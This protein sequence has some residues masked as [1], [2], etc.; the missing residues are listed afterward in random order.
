MTALLLLAAQVA[1]EQAGGP[2][3]QLPPNSPFA[4]GV[5]QGAATSETL[6]LTVADIIRR[7][8]EHNLGVLL[9]EE[10]M[11]H[12]AG[13]RR[14]AL[15]ELLPNLNARIS[16]SRQRNNLEAF[17]FSGAA[18][19]IPRVVGPF[20]VFDARVF[21]S[22]S[23]LDRRASNETRAE[24]HN[25][26]A[27]R[28]S[29]RSARDLV[30]LVAANA[31]LEALAADARASSARSQLATS[32]ALYQ[33]AQ[34]LKQGGIIAGIDVVRAEVRL[35]GDRLRVTSSQNDLEKTRLQLARVIGLPVGQPFAV[36]AQLPNVPVP[37]LTVEEALAQAYRERPDYLSA[38]ERVKAAEAVRAAA[39]SE[40]L[41]SVRVNAD[42]GALGLKATDAVATYSL[43]GSVNIPI[44]QGG[45][46][47]GR[48]AQADADLR[49]RRA[50]AEDMR[51]EIYYDV[52]ASFL[53]LQATGE[54]LQVATRSRELANQELTQAR[55]RFAAGVANNIEVV[56]AQQSVTTAD[57]QYIDAL[58][59]F[60]VAKAVLARSLGDAEAAVQ[61]ILGISTP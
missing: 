33:Q 61:R 27:A 41:P 17:G 47:Q 43:S 42:Y 29:Y 26:E 11:S 39:S 25:V 24:T 7:A 30:V 58:L 52:R 19:N 59:G 32:Q 15:S 37:D 40:L 36:S 14:A 23:V 20:N 56:Q 55:D 34:D 10:S 4:G 53:D 6:Q 9:S 3:R 28:H 5:P 38:L 22:Q 13:V 50:E 18:F 44:F 54:Q 1:A 8:L 31:Y 12:A 16:E 49:Q 46:T 2:S 51:A 60:D 21:L 57:E 45:R 35:N 48:I